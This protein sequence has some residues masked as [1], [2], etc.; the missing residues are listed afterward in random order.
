MK[1]LLTLLGILYTNLLFA[2]EFSVS[3]GQ[4]NFGVVTEISVDSLPI[5]I[6]NNSSRTLAITGYRFYTTYGQPAF[7]C[8]S[9]K[10][11][12]P[13]GGS[14]VIYI[15]FQPRHNIL[16]NTELLIENNGQR[17]A[18]RVDLI[19]Q[20]RYSKTYY[21]A[22]ENLEQE[23]LKTALKSITGQNYINLIY[24]PARDTMFM[25]IDNMKVNGQG[26]NQNTI[27][28]VYTGRQA[29]GYI[30]RTDCQNT[31]S[32][33]TE[34][35]FPQGFFNTMEPMRSDLHHLFPTDD[36]ANNTRGN[37]PFGIVNNPTWSQG[38]SKGNNSAF[39]P[40][41]AHKGK[42]SRSMLYFL[43]RY[44]NYSNFVTTADETILKQ[45]HTQFP[46]DVIESTRNN[47]IFVGQGNRNPFVDYP[48]F[49]ERINSYI[50]T[51]VTGIT[52]SSDLEND[53]ILFGFVNPTANEYYRYWLVNNGNQ[54]VTF[55]NFNFSSANQFSFVNATG[56]AITLQ[57]GEAGHVDIKPLQ[58]SSGTAQVNMT[59]TRTYSSTTQ[60]SVPIIA[61]L[62][63]TGISENE[64][65]KVIVY[66]NPFSDFICT[67]NTPTGETHILD[68][69]GRVVLIAHEDCIDTESLPAGMYVIEKRYQ[70]SAVHSSIVKY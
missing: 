8:L 61:S 69:T 64:I 62:S 53:S 14:T 19:G 65:D 48:Q 7:S 16:H 54:P 17:G 49:A 37:L 10:P 24:G 1:Q 41:D 30:D 31:F 18:L 15:R 3:P 55:S 4:L 44:Q 39:E 23:S 27:E 6:T 5:T 50:S 38:G 45:W 66:P 70:G 60:L 29:V 21:N 33:N 40:R 28:C 57:P 59:F 42:A 46:P 58:I 2:Q 47:R 11:I 20:G 36:L 51:S 63:Y 67:K 9:G 12:I 68:L 43:I 22:S 52:Y 56:G 25:I 26:A 32:F 34:H 35:T 13:A